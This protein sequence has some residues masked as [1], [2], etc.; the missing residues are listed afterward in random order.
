MFFAAEMP[1]DKSELE[2]EHYKKRRSTYLDLGASPARVELQGEVLFSSDGHV[3]RT[4]HATFANGKVFSNAAVQVEGDR[5]RL[6][7]YDGFN[8]VLADGQLIYWGRSG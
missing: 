6:H 5:M 7:G 1:N 3:L 4:A 8:Y 2:S